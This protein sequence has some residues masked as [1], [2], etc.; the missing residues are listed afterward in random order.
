M[1]Q[2]WQER[3]PEKRAKLKEQFEQSR[4][5]KRV[6]GPTRHYAERHADGVHGQWI[7][8]FA[9]PYFGAASERLA[10]YMT[11]IPF[12]QIMADVK[13]TLKGDTL[14]LEYGNRKTPIVHGSGPNDVLRALLDLED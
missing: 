13:A 11:M 1:K 4:R 10:F 8:H 5:A 6:R 14:W 2:F 7:G 9:M 3:D 12:M